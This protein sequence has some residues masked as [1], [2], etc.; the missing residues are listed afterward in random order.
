MIKNGEEKQI[1]LTEFAF[2]NGNN[3]EVFSKT[4]KAKIDAELKNI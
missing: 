3:K 2:L 1:D 4:L